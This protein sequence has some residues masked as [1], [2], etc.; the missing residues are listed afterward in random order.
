MILEGLVTT[1]NADGTPHVAPMGPIVREEGAELVLRPFH[2]STTF[3]NLKRTG[4]GVFHVTDDVEMLARAAVGRL[5][6][7]PLLEPAKAVDGWILS[8]ACRWL[9]FRVRSADLSSERA[10]FVADVVDRG[11]LREFFGFNRAKHAV[12]EAAILATR[13]HIL[14]KAEL[15]EQLARLEPWVAK[16]GGPPERRAFD[17]LV[18][19]IQQAGPP[20]VISGASIPETHH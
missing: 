8:G 4:V 5:E 3:A 13:V 7:L 14:S 16:T 20:A 2:T 9:A 18:D 1:T 6:I 17:F 19:Y 10:S 12:V 15:V 11:T